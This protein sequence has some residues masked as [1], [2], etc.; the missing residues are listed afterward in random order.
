M[1][2]LEEI[3]SLP[4][5]RGI[6][7]HAARDII[8]KKLDEN[9][10]SY[11]LQE[12]NATIPKITKAELIADN[13]T[14]S[15]I[16]ASFVSG[17]ITKESRLMS[18]FDTDDDKSIIL[19]NP[20]SKGLCLH[21]YKENYPAVAINKDDIVKVVMAKNIE[22]EVVV[23]KGKYIS[24]N[25]L[26]GNAINS[27]RVIFAHYDSLI[28]KGALDNAGSVYVLFKLIKRHPEL[29]QDNLFVFAGCEE[30]SISNPNGFYGFEMFD[31]AYRELMDKTKEI[32]VLDGVGIGKP[33]ITK[34]NVDWIFGIPRLEE[35][36]EKVLWLQND[37]ELI[38]QY[39]HT[40]LDTIEILKEKY[41]EQAIQ[42]LAQMLTKD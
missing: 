20:M 38:M 12:F 9:N 13:R 22:G 37:Q 26:V 1:N 19:F 33:S 40:E 7:E 15:C 25:I 39:Y 6:G 36:K 32:I 18:S 8:K 34:D 2:L 16:G 17:K 4:P 10:I 5:R 30:E 28:G 29:I 24:T 31:T 21:T 3:T 27:K 14:I 23:D 42:I 35:I 11:S 41:L